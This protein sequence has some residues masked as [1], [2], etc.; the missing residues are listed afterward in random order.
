MRLFAILRLFSTKS[1][2]PGQPPEL[3]V[4]LE[5]GIHLYRKTVRSFVS[6]ADQCNSEFRWARVVIRISIGTVGIPKLYDLMIFNWNIEDFAFQIKVVRRNASSVRE[7]IV[8]M[9]GPDNLVGANVDH[10]R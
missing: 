2:C 10:L 3:C 7:Q 5:V 6:V 9:H 4:V 1:F 8:Q